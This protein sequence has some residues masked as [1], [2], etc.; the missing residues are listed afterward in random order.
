MPVKKKNLIQTIIFVF[1]LLLTLLFFIGWNQI[2]YLDTRPNIIISVCTAIYFAGGALV[3]PIAWF[4]FVLYQ[5]LKM[6]PEKAESDISFVQAITNKYLFSSAC[7]LNFLI[8]MIFIKSFDKTTD[9][10]S[11]TYL[12]FFIFLA[13]MFLIVFMVHFTENKKQKIKPLVILFTIMCCFSVLWYMNILLSVKFRE[14]IFFEERF[15]YFFTYQQIYY[16]I[17]FLGI[18]YFFSCLLLYFNITNRL[19]FVTLLLN[20]TMFVLTFYNIL[21]II[22]FF[23]YI[24]MNSI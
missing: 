4:S 8:S 2:M 7:F 12:L 10:I 16:L 5:Q 3:I 14:N 17:I 1:Y 24:N 20:I 19:K 18:G 6:K 22:S 15:F 23:N 11:S 21:Y 13:I 9:Y